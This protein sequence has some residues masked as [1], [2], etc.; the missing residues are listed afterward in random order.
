MSTFKILQPGDEQALEAFL[1]Q[2]LDSSMFLIGNLRAS[3]LVDTGIPYTGTYAAAFENSKIVG[4]V[5]HFWN[6]NLICQAAQHI[7]LLYPLVV[8]ASGRKIHGAM[9]PHAQVAA[10]RTLLDLQ[11]QQIQMDAY[12]GLFSLALSD[13]DLP[14]ALRNGSVV[15]RRMIDADLEQAVVWRVA[16]SIE[17]LGSE[18]TPQLYADSRASIERTFAE[19]RTGVLEAEGKLVAMS[20]F[21]TTIDEAVQVGGVWTPPALRR[22]GYAR[23]VVA[24]SLR[25]ARAEGVQRAI[26]F[27]GDR[28]IAAQKAYCAIGFQGVGD[29]GLLLLRAGVEIG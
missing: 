15:G 7:D 3:G 24:A 22:R 13:L 5:A 2:H 26:L 25:D 18:E 12:E 4:V 29:F 6:G 17:T 19:R 16:Y 20:S 11:P 1:L 28:H 8:A 21:N 14:Q 9:G 10:I 27:T 23:A